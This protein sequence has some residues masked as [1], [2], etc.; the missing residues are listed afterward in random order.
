MKCFYVF[1]A[2]IISVYSSAD[3]YWVIKVEGKPRVFIP[4]LNKSADVVVGSFVRADW[5]ITA[6]SVSRITVICESGNSVPV[7]RNTTARE[8]CRQNQ[9]IQGRDLTR[10]RTDDDK[11]FPILLRPRGSKVIK[12]EPIRW[13]Y[14]GN[15]DIYITRLATNKTD[16]IRYQTGGEFNSAGLSDVIVPGERYK[17]AICRSGTIKYCSSNTL[18]TIYQFASVNDIQTIEKSIDGLYS[19]SGFSI[20]QEFRFGLLFAQQYYDDVLDHKDN[21]NFIGNLWAKYVIGKSLMVTGQF[22]ESETYFQLLVDSFLVDKAQG[23]ELIAINSCFALQE[24]YQYFEGSYGPADFL[25]KKY[26][27]ICTVY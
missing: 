10:Y 21:K 9:P 2:L 13:Q 8:Q 23:S 4:E 25:K 6:N 11:K 17:I 5:R 1:V 12:A 7:G 22:S 16:V 15:V 18:D 26:L 20:K 19:D 14:S 27:S 24:L 3:E